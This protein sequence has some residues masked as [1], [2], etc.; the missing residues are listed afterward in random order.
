[1]KSVFSKAKNIMISCLESFMSVTVE[2]TF[3]LWLNFSESIELCWDLRSTLTFWKWIIKVRSRN[4]WNISDCSSM[5]CCLFTGHKRQ[6]TRGILQPKLSRSTS[7]H[8]HN[9][10][11]L[12]GHLGVFLTRTQMEKKPNW[13]LMCVCV[14]SPVTGESHIRVS[15]K[16]K[17]KK[18]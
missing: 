10:A 5:K 13:E 2:M 7:G 16:I 18:N 12:L 8:F 3:P 15:V 9:R 11:E 6:R 17:K 14:R 4:L 1:M